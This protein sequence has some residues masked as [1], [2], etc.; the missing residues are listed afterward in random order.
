MPN[1]GG[2]LLS[3][4]VSVVLIASAF[5]IEVH[6]R[7]APPPE[8][9]LRERDYLTRMHSYDAPC[10]AFAAVPA[11]SPT[12]R[13]IAVAG[14]SNGAFLSEE[15][16]A[17]AVNC[18][19][20]NLQV[21]RCATP[22]AGPHE[23]A[24]QLRFLAEAD[25][26]EILVVFGNNHAAVYPQRSTGLAA[27]EL[28]V[29]SRALWN[30]A[31]AWFPPPSTAPPP[32]EPLWDEA[33]ASIRDAGA[34]HPLRVVIPTRNPWMLRG[35]PD[36][37]AHRAAW[38][39][40]VNQPDRA[41]AALATSRGPAA[42]WL[43][44]AHSAD[45]APA[46]AAAAFATVPPLFTTA[47]AFYGRY[48]PFLAS[49]GLPHLDLWDWLTAR[50]V[51]QPPGWDVFFDGSHLHSHMYRE[52]AHELFPNLGAC[53][54]KER[55]ADARV[56]TQLLLSTATIHGDP[57]RP[58]WQQRFYQ[59]SLASIQALRGR[60]VGVEAELPSLLDDLPDP[61]TRWGLWDGWHTVRGAP[62]PG[63]QPPTCETAPGCLAI[64]RAA[65]RAGDVAT[66]DR[67]LP[68]ALAAYPD[69]GALRAL[70]A[71]RAEL[72]PAAQ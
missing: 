47:E 2:I 18:P 21:V 53:E 15:L 19:D 29:Q 35:A 5:A 62:P 33:F 43:A 44:A 70:A 64:L 40:N 66:V 52:L 72:L 11:R 9:L 39:L 27:R 59:S 55:A 65:V 14:E 17:M 38:W 7:R 41:L 69:D 26:D 46:A 4:S 28:L 6:A 32:L 3:L 56:F 61:E 49:S 30:L 10:A 23:T 36:D 42:T 68:P 22:A 16:E 50:S 45:G 25:V 34:A 71:L 57:V 1:R 63:A 54:P 48:R 20:L 58:F 24:Q 51:I 67:E 37:A 8:S 60:A 13:R 31:T 12:T